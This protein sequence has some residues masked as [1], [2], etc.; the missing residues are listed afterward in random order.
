M[1]E[2]APDV[3]KSS[4]SQPDELVLEW[5]GPIELHTLLCGGQ[6]RRR[7]PALAHLFEPCRGIDPLKARGRTTDLIRIEKDAPGRSA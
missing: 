3:A 1:L 2:E 7:D 5:V 4:V 6:V